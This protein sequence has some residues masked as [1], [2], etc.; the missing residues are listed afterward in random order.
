MAKSPKELP[1]TILRQM[2]VLAT[3]GFSLVAA[4]A[5]NDLIKVFIEEF[6]KPYVSKGSGIIAQ[7]IY[8]LAITIFVVLITYQLAW[9]QEKFEKKKES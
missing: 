7:L 3:S 1:G 4:L 6:V 5:W 8:A 9:I 2:A